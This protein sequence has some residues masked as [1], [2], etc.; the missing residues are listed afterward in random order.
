MRSC[1]AA[2]ACR[3]YFFGQRRPDGLGLLSTC[4]LN[5]YF[6]VCSAL[7]A[8]CLFTDT[9]DNIVGQM[10][11][12]IVVVVFGFLFACSLCAY[13][14]CISFCVCSMC[15]HIW[16]HC[17]PD[18]LLGSRSVPDSWSPAP[19]PRALM[20]PP[21]SYQFFQ[22]SFLCS[23]FK[24]FDAQFCPQHSSHGDMVHFDVWLIPT[25]KWMTLDQQ[26]LVTGGQQAFN[27]LFSPS[28]WILCPHLFADQHVPRLRRRS[29]CSG[30]LDRECA[31][32]VNTGVSCDQVS[33]REASRPNNH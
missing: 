28:Y 17:R 30:H 13:V 19:Q 2:C 15:R 9:F 8:D 25:I 32:T 22:L 5:I 26:C 23:I 33:D 14:L 20:Y 21:G 10:V 18:G 31:S 4:A 16:Q 24:F 27:I 11:F 6:C 1:R 29:I 7:C 3:H 12:L